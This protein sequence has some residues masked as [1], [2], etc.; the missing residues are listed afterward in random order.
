MWSRALDRASALAE[1]AGDGVGGLIDG[2]GTIGS[3]A[4]RALDAVD[5]L[6]GDDDDKHS[7]YS[8]EDD[9]RPFSMQALREEQRR[10]DELLR[11]EQHTSLRSRGASYDYSPPPSPPAAS[12]GLSNRV[13]ELT[14]E[15]DELARERDELRRDR[16]AKH[17]EARRLVQR[18]RAIERELGSVREKADRADELQ[19]RLDAGGSRQETLD[20]LVA[21]YRSLEEKFGR[22][23]QRALEA[24]QALAA[25]GSDDALQAAEAKATTAVRALAAAER[26]ANAKGDE[27]SRA[28]ADAQ[29]RA[30]CLLYTS[31]SP[32]DLSTSRM[33]SS[34]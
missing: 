30:A 11:G 33:P 16:Q 9:R 26:R 14:R 13:A 5:D 22:A 25:Q 21:K 34:A 20:K 8:S 19:R 2:A 10:R 12:P 29:Q 17:D 18:Y 32:R 23:K 7:D 1:R 28:V 24:E 15:R 31:P 27:E 6:I 3:A 4:A